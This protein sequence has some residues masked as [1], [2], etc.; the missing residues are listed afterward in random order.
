M[1]LSNNSGQPVK[2]VL[3]DRDGVLNRKAAEGSYIRNYRELE[4]LPG[5][6][7]AIRILN[8]S[9]ILAIII[10]NQRGIALGRFTECDLEAIHLSLKAKLAE[11]SAHVDA[12]YY[13]PHEYGQCDCRKPKTGMLERAFLDFPVANR[14]NTVLIGDSANDIEAGRAFGIRTILITGD[15]GQSN[16]GS[17]KDAPVADIYSASLLQAVERV[18]DFRR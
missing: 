10:T 17:A 1:S 9:G 4:L 11:A 14:E 7:E 12:I 2:A 13:C 3:L 15:E 8:Q 16:Y 5:V 18:V 6:P